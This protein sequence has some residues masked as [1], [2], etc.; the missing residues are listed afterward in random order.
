MKITKEFT[1]LLEQLV[2][3]LDIPKNL[4]EE[5][6]NRYKKIGKCLGNGEYPQSALPEEIF[7]QGSFSLGTVIKPLS[8]NQEY[9]L[10]LVL[11]LKRVTRNDVSQKEIMDSVGKQLKNDNIYGKMQIKE[12]RFCWTLKYK[13]SIAFHIDIVPAIYTEKD[14]QKVLIEQYNYNDQYTENSI[15][16]TD[17]TKSEYPTITKDWRL[18]NSRGF[19][20]WFRK[21]SEYY[22]IQKTFAESRDIQIHDVPHYE[23]KTTLQRVVQILKYHRDFMFAN[24]KENKPASIIITALAGEVY[25]KEKDIEIAL[26]NIINKMPIFLNQHKGVIINPIDPKEKFSDRWNEG[27]KGKNL[28]EAFYKWLKAVKDTFVSANGAKD[29]ETTA[30]ILQKNLGKNIISEAFTKYGEAI[31]E[32]RKNGD[33]FLSSTSGIISVSGSKKVKDHTFWGD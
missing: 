27:E 28:K 8:K 31:V 10:D 4:Y 25:N 23:V 24:N 6:E 5:A 11:P 7:A 1:L 18:S 33:L 32:K 17:K 21:Q 2:E 9:D 22:V 3:V 30:N 20:E 14:F 15:F 13:D 16:I 12:G 29:I 19:T 26:F